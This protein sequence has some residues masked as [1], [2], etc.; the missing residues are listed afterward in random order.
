MKAEVKKKLSDDNSISTY[1]FRVLILCPQ[2]FILSEKR[3]NL[4]GWFDGA[5]W[6]NVGDSWVT[7]DGEILLCDWSHFR[8]LHPVNPK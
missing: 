3:V 2:A 6:K 7:D 8:E 5:N 1:G 4:I